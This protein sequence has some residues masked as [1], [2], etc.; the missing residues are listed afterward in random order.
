VK[1]RIAPISEGEMCDAPAVDRILVGY[2]G[3]DG[4]RRALERAAAVS[5]K[6]GG[7]LVVATVAEALVAPETSAMDEFQPVPV[8]FIPPD[9]DEAER[10]LDEA[11]ELLGAHGESADYV[12]LSGEPAGALVEVARDRKATLVVIGTHHESRF[13]RFLGSSVTD[14]VTHGVDCDVLVV[15]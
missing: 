12:W 3:S 11:K 1:I 9:H 4:S 10:M 7:S 13:A 14:D 2:D 15:R 5:E 8:D 6:T